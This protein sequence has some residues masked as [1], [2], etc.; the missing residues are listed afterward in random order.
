MRPALAWRYSSSES[1]RKRLQARSMASISARRMPCASICRDGS[2]HDDGGRRAQGA[3]RT[4]R[5]AGFRRR[6]G[7]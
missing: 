5:D 3:E 6:H 7:R 2:V 4:R 1:E